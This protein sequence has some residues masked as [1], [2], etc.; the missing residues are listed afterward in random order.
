[1]ISCRF[2]ILPVLPVFRFRHVGKACH[3]LGY[4]L[5]FILSRNGKGRQILT[6]ECHHIALGTVTAEEGLC[7]LVV[8]MAD[9]QRIPLLPPSPSTSSM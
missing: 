9:N 5:P 7:R 4:L 3:D 8:R 2:N 1:M 6:Y